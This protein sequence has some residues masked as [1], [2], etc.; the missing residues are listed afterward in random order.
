MNLVS[1][2]LDWWADLIKPS[3]RTIITYDKCFY[4]NTRIIPISNEPKYS[5]LL[6]EYQRTVDLCYNCFTA[7]ENQIY[8]VITDKIVPEISISKGII[9]PVIIPLERKLKIK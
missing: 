1:V 7:K 3:S 5:I 9:L 4:C 8:T 6:D 2:W